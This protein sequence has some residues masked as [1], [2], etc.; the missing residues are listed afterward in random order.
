MANVNVLSGMLDR[1]TLLDDDSDII[2]IIT[3]MTKDCIIIIIIMTRI[4][5]HQSG[6]CSIF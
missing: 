2:G 6:K 1:C 3:E 4:I 5:R